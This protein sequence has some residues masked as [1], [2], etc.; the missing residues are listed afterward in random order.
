MKSSCF[1]LFLTLCFLV[2]CCG[3]ASATEYC[4]VVNE[5]LLSGHYFVNETLLSI[6]FEDENGKVGFYDKESGYVQHP[7]YDEVFDF[8]CEDSRYP[9]L[10]GLDHRYGYAN[11]ATGEIV[12]PLQYSGY[13]SCSEFLNGFALV[14]TTTIDQD[15]YTSDK[16]IL[17]DAEG[18]QVMFPDDI[19]PD[20][21]VQD[22]GLLVVSN[23]SDEL[24]ILQFG[25]CNIRGEVIVYP[26][27]E[28]ICAFQNGYASF[29][30]DER[31]GH[32]D[33]QGNII[34]APQFFLCEEDNQ[35]YYFQ[36]NGTATFKLA[37]GT[38]IMID[39]YGNIIT[40]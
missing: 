7:Y 1:A 23:R 28:W 17:I 32:M 38:C 3:T 25:L 10:V 24:S 12:I 4:P 39:L 15:G 19:S 16:L 20:G 14:V 27:Y 18:R 5:E 9:I 8:C 37:D 33:E 34:V 29:R 40:D 6:I 35:G 31:W 2:P 11:R 13:T 26:Q 30:Q 22:N 36:D 21:Y